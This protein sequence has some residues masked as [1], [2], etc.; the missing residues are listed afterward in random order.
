M[1]IRIRWSITEETPHWWRVD[2]PGGVRKWY[3]SKL[4]AQK[5]IKKMKEKSELNDE[6]NK[7]LERYTSLQEEGSDVPGGSI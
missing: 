3:F 4:N 2:G 7:A 1:R 6:L 5:F